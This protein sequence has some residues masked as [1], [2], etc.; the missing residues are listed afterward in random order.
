M[1]NKNVELMRG[2]PEIAVRKLAIPIMISMLL[3]ASYNIVDGIWVAGLGQAAIA[4]IGFVTPIFMILN[5]VSV[6]L[7][8]GATSSISRAVGAKDHERANKS[9][10]HALLIFVLASL[11]LTVVL[12]FI[13][14]PLIKTYGASGQS[15]AEGLK[16]GT[17][18]FLGLFGFMLANGGS[19]ILR[20]E[21][22]MTRAMYAMIV[23]VVLNFILDPIFI[24]ILNLGSAGASLAT[25]ISSLGSATV[26]MYWILIK[27]DT[28]VHVT[29]KDFEFDSKIFI[30]ILKVGIPASLDMF[31]MS[32]AMSIYLIFISSIAGEYGIAAFT[33]GQRLYLFAIMPLTAIGSAVAAVSGSAYGAR[34][35]DYLS[36][37]HYYGTNFAMAFGLVMVFI[38]VVFAP[39]LSLIFAYTPETANLVPEITNFLRIASFGLLLVGIGMPSSFMYQ[40]IGRG[41]TS[42]AWTIIREVIF[43][44]SFTYLFGI[45]LNWGL[46]GIWTGL[47]VGRMLASI[48]NFIYARYTIS[49][50]RKEFQ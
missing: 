1:S 19:G 44:V 22:D 2:E 16:Y 35:A 28:Y 42:L 41:T 23:S 26:I 49:V 50:I 46:I 30:D 27:K 43:T 10:T 48:L 12:L 4:G 33:S 24:Y 47:A 14:E 9:A 5:G 29:F 15:L 37:A 45:I 40:G 3:T 31:M 32:L 13:Q 34:N 6:G 20:G 18:L 7:G 36:R 21:G 17:P 8:N 39:Q 11:L 38:L 25:I